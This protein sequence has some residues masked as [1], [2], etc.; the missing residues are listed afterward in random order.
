MTTFTNLAIASDWYTGSGA[1]TRL[2]GRLRRGIRLPP[3]PFPAL[4]RTSTEPSCGSWSRRC[5][6]CP[7]DVVA[8]TGEVLDAA[9]ADEHDRVLLQIVADARDVGR[10]LDPRGQADAGDLPEGRVRLLGGLGIDAHA[11]AP[12]LR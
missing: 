8:D 7:D 2:T 12:P 10:D 11:D 6:G 1:T 3:C 9:A 4:L 5:R